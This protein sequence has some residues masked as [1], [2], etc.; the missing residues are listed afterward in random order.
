MK[1]KINRLVIGAALSPL[2]G[3]ADN[4]EECAKFDDLDPNNETAVRLMIREYFLPFY[5]RHYT[6]E[7]MLRIKEAFMYFLTTDNIDWVREFDSLLFPFDLPNE[8]RNFYLWLW[9]ECFPNT[10]YRTANPDDYCVIEDYDDLHKNFRFRI[11]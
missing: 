5:S 6:P 11:N 8:P 3:Y 9:D 10:D 4:D 2:V 7:D 1:C